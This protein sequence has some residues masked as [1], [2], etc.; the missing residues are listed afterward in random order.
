MLDKKCKHLVVD[1][2]LGLF[3]LFEEDYPIIKGVQNNLTLV[4]KENK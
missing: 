2:C 3:K 4:P 1:T